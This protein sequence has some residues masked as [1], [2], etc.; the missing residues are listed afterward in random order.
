MHRPD[1]P[2]DEALLAEL[3]NLDSSLRIAPAAA[4]TSALVRLVRRDL[5]SSALAARL[6]LTDWTVLPL[7]RDKFPALNAFQDRLDALTLLQGQDP[8]T[9]LANRRV[10]D[11]TLN[12]EVERSSRF[13]TPI[14]LCIL[15][16][17]DFK[18][19]NDTY[20]HPCGDTVLQS[21]ATLLRREVRTIDTV[22]RIGGEEFA[23]LLPGTGLVRAQKFLERVLAS[24]RATRI[25]CEDAT[26]N[27]T[28]SLGVASYRGKEMPDP[29]KLVAAADKALYKAKRTGKNRMECAPLLDLGPDLKKTLVQQNEKQF[30]FS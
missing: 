29:A 17:D 14:S 16:L 7:H 18:T 1:V 3:E 13:K 5:N 19:I 26:L 24:I 8:L 15:D 25:Q 12:L 4:N 30:L 2:A 21:M 20:G 10:F 22:A 9:G 27:F 6:K 28:A 23:L 11:Q